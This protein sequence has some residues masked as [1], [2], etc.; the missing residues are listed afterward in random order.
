MVKLLES[1]SD[2]LI[3]DDA[4]LGNKTPPAEKKLEDAILREQHFFW[5]VTDAER[6][7][8]TLTLKTKSQR[9]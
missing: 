5:V 1:V 4:A 8:D 3:D 7:R 9:K 2:I 6:K